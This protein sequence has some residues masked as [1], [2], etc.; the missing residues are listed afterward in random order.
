MWI[1]TP[2]GQID[3]GAT[4]LWVPKFCY[5]VNSGMGCK[6]VLSLPLCR[7]QNDIFSYR[8]GEFASHQTS[9]IIDSNLSLS[10]SDCLVKCWNDCS[11]VGFNSSNDNGTG[12]ILWKGSNS[13]SDNSSVISAWK[14]VIRSQ[15]PS[16]EERASKRRYGT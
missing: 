13:F 5:G 12:C 2:E 10:I 15:N 1:L 7:N 8:N 11:C 14:Y 3:G 6:E 16:I 9:N 4:G